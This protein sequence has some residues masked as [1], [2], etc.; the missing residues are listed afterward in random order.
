MMQLT[1]NM[2]MKMMMITIIEADHQH[3]QYQF[4]GLTSATS[5]NM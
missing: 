3:G 1:M 2:I 4:K 5:N